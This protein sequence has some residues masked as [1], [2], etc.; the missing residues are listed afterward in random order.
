M[1]YLEN[2][3]KNK[4]AEATSEKLIMRY[5]RNNLDLFV[6][7]NDG[8]LTV[9]EAS[10]ELNFIDFETYKGKKYP[11]RTLALIPSCYEN[12]GEESSVGDI[13]YFTI[14]TEE[15]QN[16]FGEELDDEASKIDSGIYFYLDEESF[17]LSG[18]I[19]AKE[20]LDEEYVFCSDEFSLSVT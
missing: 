11:T 8:T 20:C 19:I 14:A 6:R 15:L 10:M 13:Q 3:L 17:N 2:V 12:N 4:I 1:S 18:E 16:A 5:F 7:V 9:I